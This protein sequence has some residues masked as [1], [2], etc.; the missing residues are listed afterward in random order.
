M[1]KETIFNDKYISILRK[2]NH[3][4]IIIKFIFSFINPYILF[5]LIE[6]DKELA[7]SINSL[8]KPVKKNNN[9][10]SKTINNNIKML[11]NYKHFKEDILDYYP[12]NL[13]EFEQYFYAQNFSKKT[14]DPSFINYKL[15][16]ILKKNSEKN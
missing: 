6:K 10:L 1:I 14:I 16:F 3:K 9:K 11:L 8:F 7:S 5:K 12:D 15:K 13:Y 2:V 4:P